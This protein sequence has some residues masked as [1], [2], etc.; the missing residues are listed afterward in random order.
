MSERKEA[1]LLL[2]G[3]I[4]STTVL[5]DLAFKGYKVHCLIFD[6]GQSLIKEVE[7]SRENAQA[8]GGVPAVL[9]TP[10]DFL[11]GEH[12]L[13]GGGKEIPKGR[14][15]F[16]IGAGGTPDSYVPFR[17]GIFLA[18]AIAYGESAGIEEIFCGGNGL[19]SG[20]YWD[21]TSEFARIMGIAGSVGT[22]PG[23]TPLIQYP[24]AEVAKSEIVKL[25][26]SY[27]F[28]Y[29][30]TWSCYLNGESHCGECDSCKFRAIAMQENGLDLE[31]RKVYDA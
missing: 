30:R 14:S 29:A 21:D 2:S 10:F 23:Y 27:G 16:E 11:P 3:G 6:Y 7:L 13:L 31:G 17:N 24:F 5:V 18:Y 9:K 19:L 8:M 20:N 26:Q 12:A 28:N 4:D 1:I 25:G 22:D 15:I